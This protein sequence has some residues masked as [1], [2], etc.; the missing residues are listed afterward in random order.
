MWVTYSLVFFYIKTK[1]K[2]NKT[3]NLHHEATQIHN[4][5]GC[6]QKICQN[7]N[8]AAKYIPYNNLKQNMEM[9]SFVFER[10]EHKYRSEEDY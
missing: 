3:Y 4:F 6:K 2:R 1:G 7:D 5:N 9:L 8:V 10:F